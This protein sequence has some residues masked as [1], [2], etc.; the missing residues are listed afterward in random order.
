MKRLMLVGLMSSML[1]G[2]VVCGDNTNSSGIDL[3]RSAIM[4]LKTACA[5]ACLNMA[6][7]IYTNAHKWKAYEASLNRFLRVVIDED[8]PLKNIYQER[9]ILHFE[10]ESIRNLI[11]GTVLAGACA[12]AAG[13]IGR[14]AYD[15]W[16]RDAKQA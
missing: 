15:Y 16:N 3:Q 9:E 2:Q 7:G 14:T 1:V 6:Y 12:F 8:L 4:G 13:F 5:G 10:N 11:Q